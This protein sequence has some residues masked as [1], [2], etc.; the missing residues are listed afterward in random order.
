M[1]LYFLWL[2]IRDNRFCKE[3][4][5]QRPCTF[6]R[7]M[8]NAHYPITSKG[9]LLHATLRKRYLDLNGIQ[10]DV[11]LVGTSEDGPVPGVKVEAERSFDSTILKVYK[12][13]NDQGSIQELT[14]TSFITTSGKVADETILKNFALP[15]KSWSIFDLQ[16][17]C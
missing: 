2:F 4:F 1:K 16:T 11:V 7:F 3:R 17:E 12:A 13:L 5:S 6:T 10:N 15:I 8:F 9:E 14:G